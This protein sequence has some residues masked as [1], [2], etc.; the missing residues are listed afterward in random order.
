MF[1][2]T[3]LSGLGAQLPLT[4]NEAAALTLEATTPSPLVA[5][6]PRPLVR[7]V[8]PVVGPGYAD[9]VKSGGGFVPK[10]VPPRP[11]PAVGPPAAQTSGASAAPLLLSALAFLLFRGNA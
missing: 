4:E 2:S 5:P 7:P 8:P 1:V 6:P 9:Y 11:V 10:K 3:G